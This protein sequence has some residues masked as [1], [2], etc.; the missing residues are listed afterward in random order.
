MCYNLEKY[1]YIKSVK[2]LSKNNFDK[3]YLDVKNPF[4]IYLASQI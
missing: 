4:I 2:K 3:F 1:E